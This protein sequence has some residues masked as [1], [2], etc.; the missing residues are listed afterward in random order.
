[1]IWRIESTA[2]GP[3]WF[4]A[5]RVREDMPLIGGFGA[6]RYQYS[7][8]QVVRRVGNLEIMREASSITS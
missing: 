1:M 7:N 8:P 5:V 4:A 2:P 6:H 3:L